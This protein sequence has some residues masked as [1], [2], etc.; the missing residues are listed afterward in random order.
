MDTEDDMGEQNVSTRGQ[1]MKLKIEEKKKRR[2]ERMM[3]K[4]MSRKWAMKEERGAQTPEN[5]SFLRMS[6]KTDTTHW[7]SYT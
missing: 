1:L 3:K 7:T 5:S 4:K 2:K 6:P